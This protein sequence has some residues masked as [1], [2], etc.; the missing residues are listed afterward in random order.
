MRGAGPAILLT[1]GFAATA[2][3]FAANVDDLARDHTVVTWNVRGHGASDSPTDPA[4]YSVELSVG[5]M[6][7]VLDAAGVDTAVVAGHSLGG[8][9]SLE[10]HLEH[11]ERVT[12]L[13]LIDTGPGYRRDEPREEWNRMAAR[14]ASDLELR[15]LDALSDSEELS[16]G[17]HRDAAG[18]ALAARGILR[19][20]DAR[21]IESLPA[22]D[23]PTLVVVGEHDTPFLDG[24]RYM[25]AKIPRADLAVIEG[26]R[27]APNVS[28]SAAFNGR[29][30]EFLSG[31]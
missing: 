3:M 22:I 11:R 16:A 26:A 30:R 24:C 6:T 1:H 2:Q 15:G 12:A 5:D 17:A 31:L 19:Q 21:V 8:Y 18:L 14:Y 23:V 4:R 10:F 27:H 20:H 13:V 25:A 29:M 7:A 9:L 28:H